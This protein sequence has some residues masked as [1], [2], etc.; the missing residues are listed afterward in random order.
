MTFPFSGMEYTDGV[1]EQAAGKDGRLF[2]RKPRLDCA[3]PRDLTPLFISRRY[4]TQSD[5]CVGCIRG[6]KPHG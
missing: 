1:S 3:G 2:S 5:H 6:L 4:A